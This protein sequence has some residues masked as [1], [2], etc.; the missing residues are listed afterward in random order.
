MLF[1]II[2]NHCYNI[3]Y[4]ITV[5]HKQENKSLAIRLRKEGKSYSEIGKITGTPKGTLSG[6]FSGLVWSTKISDKNTE[7][8]ITK[9]KTRMAKMNATRRE[10]LDNRYREAEEEARREF[11]QY[12]NNK[13]FIAALMLY[14]G[15]GDKTL[16]SNLIR[17]SNA[18]SV[19]LKIFNKFLNEFCAVPTERIRFWALLY[20]D[21]DEN[22]CKNFWMRELSL[23]EAN[24]YRFQVI[25]GRHTKK[26]TKKKLRYGVGNTI[27]GNKFLKVKLLEWIRLAGLEL[28]K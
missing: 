21:L 16:D 17:I 3:I 6:W 7:A 26:N 19:V 18:D 9:S 23:N 15:E 27:L 10:V 20:P 12:K 28:S 8:S 22:T 4:N 1:V 5:V 11:K 25:K 14:L 2:W 24:L 13:N